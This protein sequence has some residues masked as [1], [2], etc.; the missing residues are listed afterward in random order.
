MVIN[1][2]QYYKD[3][4]KVQVHLSVNVVNGYPLYAGCHMSHGFRNK[5]KLSCICFTNRQSKMPS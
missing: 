1:S 3:M 2:V 4:S 5:L